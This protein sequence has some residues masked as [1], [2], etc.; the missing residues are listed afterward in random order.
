MVLRE[1]AY[2]GWRAW[3]DGEPV[4]SEAELFRQIEV[5]VGEHHVEWR[6]EPASVRWGA[7][8]SGGAWLLLSVLFVVCFSRRRQQSEVN[9]AV[10]S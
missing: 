6:Y 9:G 7:I 2:P 5:P 4:R 3:I 1:L 10:G 8:V